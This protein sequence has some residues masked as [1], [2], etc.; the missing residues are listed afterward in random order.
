M[1]L[2]LD[3]FLLTVE[4]PFLFTSA[5]TA[6]KITLLQFFVL[7]VICYLSAPFFEE[8]VGRRISPLEYGAILVGGLIASLALIFNSI[9]CRL[10]EFGVIIK[11]TIWKSIVLASLQIGLGIIG[12]AKGLW[13]AELS[14]RTAQLV[15]LYVYGGRIRKSNLKA[16]GCAEFFENAKPFMIH[17]TFASLIS[18]FALFLPVIVLPSIL[19]IEL[20]GIYFLTTQL[21]HTPSSMLSQSVSKVFSTEFVDSSSRDSKGLFYRTFFGLFLISGVII[22]AGLI[23]LPLISNLIPE[24]WQELNNILDIV[25]ISAWPI[26]CVSSLSQSFNLIG[27]QKYLIVSEVTKLI[28]IASCLIYLGLNEDNFDLRDAVIALVMCSYVGYIIQFT[29]MMTL[30]SQRSKTGSCA[31]HEKS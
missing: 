7:A 20:A 26:L 9:F 13:V 19:T 5:S 14:S 25:L 29:L 6:M 4:K 28:L 11:S 21:V 10:R 18:T 12:F 3:I 30:I 27:K 23:L 2:R 31:A 15:T 24:Q 22:F 8:L 1:V 16:Y 17:T